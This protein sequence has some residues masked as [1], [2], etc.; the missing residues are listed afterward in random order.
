MSC[1]VAIPSSPVFSPSR[2]PLSC[3]AASA[4]PESVSVSSPAPS[5]AGSPLRPFGLLRAQIREEAS[6]SPKTSSAAPSVAAGSVLKR[7]RPAPLMV[8]VDGAAA[9]AAA[10]A[11]V[12]AVE[13]D[14]SN[15]VEEEGDEFAAYCRRGRGR[16]RVEMEDRHVAKVALGGDPEVALFAVFDGHGGKNAAEFA[17]LTVSNTGDCRAVLSRA[18]TAEA[19]TSDH[20]AS[21]EDER[22]R[23]ENL[24]GF[25]VNNRGTWRVQ[26]SLAVS[27]GIGDAHLKQWVVADPD[28]R[29]LL[30]DPQC[31]FLVLASDGLWDKVDNQEAIDIA[32][33]LCIGNDKTSRIAACRRLVETAGSRGSTDDISVLIIQLQKFSGSS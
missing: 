13:S 19:L 20:R 1:S 21:R 4:S 26:G 16:R 6:P 23:I 33:P 32:R 30:V 25:V 9:A 27:R 8:P 10:A 24:G 14:P 18:G 2:R 17:A 29:T 12:A 22:E 11:A 28:T 31:E 5:T 7:R 3:K 15:E